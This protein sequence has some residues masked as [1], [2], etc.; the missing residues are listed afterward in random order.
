MKLQTKLMALILA[1][2]LY[3]ISSFFLWWQAYITA[4][5]TQ[6]VVHQMR[7]DAEAKIGRL[8]LK[9]FELKKNLIDPCSK[10]YLRKALSNF[11][12]IAIGVFVFLLCRRAVSKKGR[13]LQRAQ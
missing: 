3:L 6:R 12:Y 4:G 10:K 13:I 7:L 1:I 2:I 8:P 9:Y 5:V 11:F